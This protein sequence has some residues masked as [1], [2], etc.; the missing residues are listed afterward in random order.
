MLKIPAFREKLT[1]LRERVEEG[2][3]TREEA[4]ETVDRM[5]VDFYLRTGRGDLPPAV[6]R[7]AG[8]R[9]VGVAIE[10]CRYRPDPAVNEARFD[11]LAEGFPEDHDR[12]PG[13]A[14]V[15]K[16]EA[17]LERT[18]PRVQ[19]LFDRLFGENEEGDD[20][21]QEHAVVFREE[22]GEDVV[23]KIN[24]PGRW[25]VGEQNILRYLDGLLALD[26]VQKGALRLEI[27]GYAKAGNGMPV[28]VHKQKRIQGRYVRSTGEIADLLEEQ[29]H[30]PVERYAFRR[31]VT[32]LTDV[33]EKNVIV[34]SD[35]KAWIID[36]IL[37]DRT[38]LRS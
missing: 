6:V 17:H 31:G 8:K 15:E 26:E 4:L 32:V 25:G 2:A 38:V 28:I 13:S 23:Y 10:T 37:D 33:H 21:G 36:A 12:R 19:E 11:A 7:L 14:F 20:G 35:G 29:G 1:V 34:D 16:Q 22:E 27:L 9:G 3:V 30:V 24:H 18:F 5:A